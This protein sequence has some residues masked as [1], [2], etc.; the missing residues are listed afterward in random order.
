MRFDG[1]RIY[2]RPLMWDDTELIVR[3][4]N[5]PSVADQLFSECP[6]SHQEHEAWFAKL[7]QS[8]D[9]IEF[10]I[11]VRAGEQSV[12]TIGLSHIDRKRGE[13]ELGIMLGV[14]TWRRQGIGF[15]ASELILRHAFENMHLQRI[16]LNSFADNAS[17]IRLYKSLGFS[18]EPSSQT[19][20][21]D[22]DDELNSTGLDAARGY[23]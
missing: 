7:L 5:D 17:A 1:P 3:W 9:R 18:E 23:D 20:E 22:V 14:T 21:E 8:D 4:R 13:A 10:V 11:V 15:E 6:P 2:L 19:T 12:G 16:R